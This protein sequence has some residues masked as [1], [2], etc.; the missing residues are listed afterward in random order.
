MND[1]EDTCDNVCNYVPQPQTSVQ[2]VEQSPKRILASME[3]RKNQKTMQAIK[4]VF[5][6]IVTDYEDDSSDEYIPENKKTRN[7]CGVLSCQEDI[8]IKCNLCLADTALFIKIQFVRNSNKP[9]NLDDAIS[10][11]DICTLFKTIQR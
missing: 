9:A 2:S 6:E 5:T 11:D 10:D 8:F 4:A 1:N 3:L 7:V